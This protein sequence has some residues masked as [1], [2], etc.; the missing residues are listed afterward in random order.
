MGWGYAGFGLCFYIFQSFYFGY[1]YLSTATWGAQ[2]P[3]TENKHFMVADR[4]IYIYIYTH[5]RVLVVGFKGKKGTLGGPPMQCLYTYVYIIY[6]YIYIFGA[7]K[8]L[9]GKPLSWARSSPRSLTETRT[10]IG[11]Y[12]GTKDPN[13]I[14]EGGFDFR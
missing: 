12:C 6:I 4:N 7:A 10:T 9:K 1:L 3:T 11:A 5:L 2:G 8:G 14:G 13:G